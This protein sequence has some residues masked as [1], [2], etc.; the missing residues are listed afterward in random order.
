MTPSQ[1]VALVLYQATARM[2][3]GLEQILPVALEGGEGV[4]EGA[5]VG[6]EIM[7]NIPDS[8]FDVSG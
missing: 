8:R 2:N 3:R 6:G 4:E 1:E 5:V 7:M